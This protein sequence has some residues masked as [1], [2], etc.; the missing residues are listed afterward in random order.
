M[1]DVLA[2]NAGARGASPCWAR[3]S[4]LGREAGGPAPPAGTIRR[5]AAEWMSWSACAA[6]PASWSKRPWQR[7][8]RTAP[9]LFSKTPAEAGEFARG[10]AAAGRCDSVQGLAR[11]AGGDGRW[12]ERSLE[13]RR[14]TD[15]LLS[16]LRTSCIRQCQP[17]PRFPLRDLAHRVRQPDGAVPVHCAGAVADRQ[18]ARVS[19]RPVY[20]R[21][22][23]EVAPEEGRH[24][25]HGRR[26]DHHLASWC[27][28]CCGRTCAIS[29]SG[30]R[31]RR[32]WASAS[33]GFL[34]DYAKVTKQRNLGLTA[35]RKL[36]YQFADGFRVRGGAAGHA[37][38]RR[39]SPTTM[40]I[41]FLKQFQPVAADP[42]AAGAI[43]GLTC[44][45]WRRSAFSWRWWWCSCRTR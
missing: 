29:M 7:D 34:D 22:R 26:A 3:C 32:C 23:P 5:G 9:R 40:N 30:S 43:P 36:V 10:M 42:F 25:D 33:I 45:A 35:R 20:P 12:N 8:C 21:G 27:R 44:W 28:R 31:W 37:R 13:A 38:L 17:V 39:S 18:A 1:I 16:S 24:A 19:D 11:R 6:L 14:I 2:R 4:S 15:A 41:P